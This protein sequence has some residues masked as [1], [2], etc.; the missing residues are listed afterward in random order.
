[1]ALAGNFQNLK[2]RHFGTTNSRG[3]QVR[4]LFRGLGSYAQ[5]SGIRVEGFRVQGCG[6]ELPR[7]GG[8][9]LVAVNVPQNPTSKTLNP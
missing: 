1:M 9:F 3:G 7:V 5:G 4:L 6:V 8:S 2:S